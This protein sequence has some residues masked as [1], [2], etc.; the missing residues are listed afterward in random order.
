[1]NKYLTSQ[2][3][4]RLTLLVL[5]LLGGISLH[6]QTHIRVSLHAPTRIHG[7]VYDNNNVPVPGATVV[8]KT[9][10]KTATATDIDGNFE[11]K[12]NQELPATLVFTLVGY[13]TQEVDVY[14]AD[15]SIVVTLAENI[16]Y[17]DEVVVTALGISREKK[18]LGYTTQELK[19]NQLS[20]TKESNLLNSLSGKVAGVRITNSQGD[21]GSSRIIIR[22]ETSIAG[23]NQ[24]LFIV[25]GIPVDNSQLNFGGATR[26]F[27]NAIAD[28]NPE[29]IES[30]SVLKGPNAAALYGSRAAHGVI[31]ITTKSGKGQ[32]GIGVSVNSGISFAKVATLPDFQN[33]FGQGTNGAFS[34]VDGKGGGVNDG[35]DE[36]WGPR[37][38]GR[39]IPQFYSNGVAV[40]FVAH[41]NNVKDFFET[42]VTFDNG[43]SIAGS[44][45]R[46]DFRVGVNHQNQKGTVPNSQI[47]KTNFNVNANYQ[48]TKAIKVGATANYISTDAP[49][50]PGGPSGNRAAGVMLQFLWFGRQVDINELKNNR[51]V[52]WN[53][54]YYSNPYWNAYYNTTSQK[55]DRIIGDVHLEAKIIDGLDFRFRSG[56]D[57]YN[58]RRKYKIK[59]GTNGTPYGS[60]AE[61]AYTINENNT[62]A[63]LHYTKQL[64][65]DFNLDAL[66]GFNIRNKTYENNYQKAPRLAVPDV[67]TLENSRDNLTS[68]NSYTRLRVYSAYTSAQLGY[69]NYAYLNVTARNDW[70]STLPR[71][72]RSY[73]YPSVNASLVLTDALN[74]KSNTL[75]F[76][77]L[78][79]GWSEVGNDA[80]PYQLETVY[81]FQ[82]P[83]EGNPI[84]TSSKKKLNPEL[85]PETTRSTEF[86]TELSLF[87]SRVHLDV[88]Y[89]NTNSIDQILEIKTSAASG[90][91]SRVMNA[92]KINNQGVEVQLGIVPVQTRDFKWDLGLNYSWN[93]SKVK[94][95]DYDGD[96]ENYVI[97]SS[98]GVDVL[99]SVGKSYGT[100]YGTAYLRDDAGNIVVGANGL[101]RADPVKKVLGHYTPN[102]IGG[103]SN[104]LTYKNIELSFLIDANVGGK[105]YSGTNRTGNYTGVL[106]QTLQGRGKEYGGLEYYIQS[107]GTKV[108]LNGGS[109]PAGATVYDDGMIF[110]GVYADGT[111]NNTVISA[112]QYYKASYNINEAY[113]YSATYVK[114]REIKLTYNFKKNLIK[115]IGLEGASITAVGRNLFFIY[116]DAP[117][118]DP[119]TAFN[120]GNA[121]GLESLSLPTTRTLGFNVNL[122]F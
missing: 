41:P 82:S 17:L 68:S 2:F 53:N 64:S 71:S 89:Y 120:T 45:A 121:Q 116:K 20:Q 111:P 76:L 56:T 90:Y 22:G 21:M 103:V 99:A 83:Y 50:L 60:Y 88:A 100:L 6:A 75:D 26:D 77:K 102:W 54:S 7:T 84:L 23:N 115:K 92:G 57:Y 80:E 16:N 62:E 55:R 81:N 119:E 106:E 58:D 49:A 63:I 9:A 97:G 118:I 24:P 72:N 74:I 35:V 19:S 91:T 105:I 48:L 4:L 96:I 13:K 65:A 15:E 108:L 25:D 73:F 122:K 79:G 114:F 36:S 78:R 70:S 11:L 98:G 66:G 1:M 95:L 110:E 27:R 61:D 33:A 52:N 10:A 51:D 32:K 29:D 37:L 44:D 39:L 93:K 113:V 69:K 34:F 5:V 42:G 31:L 30:M 47:K 38:D 14:D 87:K 46:Y 109:A 40:P 85:K 101:P 107:N 104:T 3:L 18:S 112:Q 86:G 94:I 12:I 67:Y 28:L 117:N 43:I 59:Y 8:L